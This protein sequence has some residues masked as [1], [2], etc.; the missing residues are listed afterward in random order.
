MSAIMDA[1]GFVGDTLDRPGAAVRGL[2]AGRPDQLLNLLPGS[3]SMGLMDPSRKVGGRDLLRQYGVAGDEDNWGNFLGGMAVDTLTNPLTYVPPAFA[4]KLFGGTKN[5]LSKMLGKRRMFDVIDVDPHLSEITS[6]RGGRAGNWVN[7]ADDLGEAAGDLIQSAPEGVWGR[8]YPG[9]NIAATLVGAPPSTTRHEVIHGL[10]RNAA[11]TG[12]TEGLPFLVKL[13]AKVTGPEYKPGVRSGIARVMDELA[14]HTLENKGAWNQVKGGADFLFGNPFSK[15]G[16][17]VRNIY[18]DL[19]HSDSPL[20]GYAYDA[21][22]Y[23]PLAAGA[24]AG[25]LG[26]YELS[27]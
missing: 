25:A 12:D 24:G 21:L 5:S 27:R 10:V 1:L 13:A 2:L 18:S 22:G 23:A 20:V 3:E 15:S 8:Y 9:K 11:N 19:I 7:S 26:A 4:S 14:A 17:A 6:V 16:R